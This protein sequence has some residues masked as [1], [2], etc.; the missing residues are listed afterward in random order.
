MR[1]ILL[2]IGKTHL[3]VIEDLLTMNDEEVL[4]SV[5]V[6]FKNGGISR[7]LD[8]GLLSQPAHLPIVVP[9]ITLA[10]NFLSIAT[11][12]EC[13]KNP[14]QAHQTPPRKMMHLTEKWIICLWR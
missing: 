13:L 2:T 4:Q 9:A 8:M 1:D 11:L 7:L 10:M 6:D 3:A 14:P 12:M 5:V